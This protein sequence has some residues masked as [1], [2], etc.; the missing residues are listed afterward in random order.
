MAPASRLPSHRCSTTSRRSSLSSRTCWLG[1]DRDRKST[2]MNSS[3]PSISYAVFCLKKKS[4]NVLPEPTSKSMQAAITPISIPSGC[5]IHF[6]LL[7]T[8]S[9]G[10]STLSLHD[11][12][13][14]SVADR[15]KDGAS[16]EAAFAPVQHDIQ[17]L[18]AKLAHMLAGD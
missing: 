16:F 12:L 4:R 17:T 7:S 5:G 15:M 10:F 8:P 11:A 18:F 3:H 13:P 6:S 2:R 9:A 1:T 14:I